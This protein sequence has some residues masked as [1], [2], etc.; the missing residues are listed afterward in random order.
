MSKKLFIRK[1]LNKIIYIS[2]IVA[3]ITAI[4]IVLCTGDKNKTG[5]KKFDYDKDFVKT[6]EE[7]GNVEIDSIDNFKDGDYRCGLPEGIS[8]IEKDGNTL[9]IQYT[10]TINA[11]GES[12]GIGVAKLEKKYK[13]TALYSV[14]NIEVEGMERFFKDSLVIKSHKD[15]LSKIKDGT[16][17]KEMVNIRQNTMKIKVIDNKTILVDD[18]EFT[19]MEYKEVEKPSIEELEKQEE[20]TR[21]NIEALIGNEISPIFQE[22]GPDSID[23]VPVENNTETNVNAENTEVTEEEATE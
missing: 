20:E 7:L 18:L 22:G 16:I 8:R 13:S 6:I 14:S 15:L 2:L 9:N 21:K 4:A 10:G 3:I 5:D 23:E 12:Y 19:R 17:K 1:H 11:G